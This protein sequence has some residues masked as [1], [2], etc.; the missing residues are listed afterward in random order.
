MNRTAIITGGASVAGM[1]IAEHLLEEGW[2]VAIIDSDQEAAKVAEDAFSG[3]DVLVIPADISDEEEMDRAFDTAVD[4]FGLCSALINC[5]GIRL[6]APFEE[7]NVEQLRETLELNLVAPFVAARA[8]FAR[9]AD[10]LVIIN[11]VSTS[12][13]QPRKGR[14]ALAASHAGLRMMTEILAMENLDRSV[15][16]NCIA[17]A[18][19]ISKRKIWTSRPTHT[20]GT[21]EIIGAVSY[22]LSDAAAVITGQTLVLGTDE[23]D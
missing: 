14:S 23:A 8:A 15:R 9:M 19:E 1:A 17:S 12:A 21:N 13:L 5:A 18:G 4:T 22:L 16:V 7:T 6:D 10:H 2:S 3:E 11:L 20:P